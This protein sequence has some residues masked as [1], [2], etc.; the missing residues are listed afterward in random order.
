MADPIV[1]ANHIDI[2]PDVKFGDDVVIEADAIVIGPG[3]TIG[4]DDRDA[5]RTPAGVRITG[6]RVVLGDGVRIARGVRMAGGVIE[7]GVGVSIARL[8]TMEASE[9]LVI[10]D[11]G[12]VGEESELL[13]RDIEIGQELW[14]GPRARIGGGSAMERTS[15]LRA[16][17]FLHLGLDT[18]INT[19]HPVEIGHEVGLGTRTSVYT[20]GAYPSRLQGFPVAFDGVSIGDFTWIPGAVINPGVHIGRNC[21]IGVN[22]LVTA[23]VPDGALAA[24]SP[25]KVIR[26]N[27][28]PRPLEHD[29]VLDFFESFLRTFAHLIAMD[30]QPER[31][32]GQVHLSTPSAKYIA[33]RPGAGKAFDDDRT[34]VVGDGWHEHDLPATWTAFDTSARRIRGATDALSD[35]LAN[36]LRRYGIRFYSRPY[37][38][39]YINWA[40]VL[41][42]L[43]PAGAA[44]SGAGTAAIN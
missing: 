40:S 33:G 9:R 2:A 37:A 10:G 32:V 7:L 6:Q 41:P 29:A 11:G 17:H 34:L 1:H 35:R 21:V 38:D 39:R 20:H 25:A 26:E 27:A 3:T 44:V 8:T 31:T 19:A 4:L 30:A 22:S 12:I 14:T 16:G 5:F 36:E 23:D 42:S 43:G 15:S 13:G 28:Y 18:F 24:G